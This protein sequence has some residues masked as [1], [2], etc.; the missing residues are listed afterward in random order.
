LGLALLEYRPNDA[1]LSQA[2]FKP[3]PA[4][5][6]GRIPARIE[7]FWNTGIV[8]ANPND[9]SVELDFY[10]SDANGAALYRGHTSL[11]GGG[12]ISTFLAESPLG[13]DLQMDMSAARSFTFSASAPIAAGAVRT[14]IN[15]RD[16]F[17]MSPLPVIDLDEAA[18][19]LTFPFYADGGGEQSE[20]QLVNPTNSLISGT[21]RLVPSLKESGPDFVYDIAPRSAAVFRTPGFGSTV[22]RGWVQVTSTN[23]TSAP[24][25]S[26]IVS[27]KTNGVTTS[28]R[29]IVSTPPASF[30]HLYTETSGDIQDQPGSMQTLFAIANPAATAASVTFEFL[31][32]RWNSTGRRGAA[33][34]GPYQSATFLLNELPGVGL[35][36]A[37]F[38]GILR[39]E[40]DPVTAASFLT[41]LN[42]H[43]ERIATALPAISTVI[44]S[45]SS[46]PRF[47]FVA[48]GAGFSTN[49]KDAFY[50]GLID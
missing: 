11:P 6:N 18:V 46:E 3:E 32:M 15:E 44:T 43:G 10:Y 37:P 34:I 5:Q 30:Y 16:E 33:I 27:T 24:A 31:D 41:R 50:L 9:A 17:L 1:L 40:G 47:L 39:V 23:G 26:L 20:I 42:G 8:L 14:L 36:H 45:S 21:V 7:N 12:R 25:G 28:T 2:V 29:T 48:K 35:F 22:H 13:P 19:P 4:V 38:Q 49:L